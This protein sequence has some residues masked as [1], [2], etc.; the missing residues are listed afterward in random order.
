MEAKLGDGAFIAY[1]TDGTKTSGDWKVFTTSFGPTDKSY[2]NGCSPNSLIDCAVEITTE[3]SGWSGDSSF[4]DASWGF[5]TTYSESAAGWG[6]PPSWSSGS[7]SQSTSPFTKDD[8][9]FNTGN[10]DENMV[11]TEVVVD[12]KD[13]L[14]PEEV[15]YDLNYYDGVE[16]IWGSDLERDNTVLL[17]FNAGSEAFVPTALAA[18]YL[19]S[20]IFVSLSASV[21]QMFL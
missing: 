5:V 7:C 4:D 8:L 15:L 10:V 14:D 11:A 16:F 18:S 3:P 9:D 19:S 12:E 1:F 2:D 21:V 20:M 17:R 6:R 13:C